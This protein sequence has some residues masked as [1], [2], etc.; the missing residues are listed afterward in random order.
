MSNLK[1]SKP[2]KKAYPL[3]VTDLLAYKLKRTQHSLRLRMDEVLKPLGLTTPQ[4]AVLAQLELKPGMSSAALARAAFITSQTM[5][6]MVL[7]LEKQKLLERSPD[8]QHGRILRAELS[9]QGQALV[10]RAHASILAVEGQML[11]SLSSENKA[12]FE[13]LLLEC[14]NNLDDKAL[15]THR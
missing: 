14:F 12:L 9:S 5:H 3:Y 8:P 13:A 15:L 7:N 10:Q 1:K 2:V 11:A 6:A 4:Y